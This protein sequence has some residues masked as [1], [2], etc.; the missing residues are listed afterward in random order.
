[1]KTQEELRLSR[2]SLPVKSSKSK[3]LYISWRYPGKGPT[4]FSALYPSLILAP[5]GLRLA[6][7][8]GMKAVGLQGHFGWNLFSLH[9]LALHYEISMTTGT[10]LSVLHGEGL[11]FVRRI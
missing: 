9:L 5:A 4:A 7:E 3:K 2:G 6:D 1:M 8:R 11:Y 10:C